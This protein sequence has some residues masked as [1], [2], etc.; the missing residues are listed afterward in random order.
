[1]G[2]L[3]SSYLARRGSNR[4]MCYNRWNNGVY[5]LTCH[6]PDGHE[7]LHRDTNGET[8]TSEVGW[9]DQHGDRE[10]T[11]EECVLPAPTHTD[12]MVSPEAIDE[13]LEANP[14]EL[15]EPVGCFNCRRG[16]HEQCI[17]DANFCACKKV[18]HE[19]AT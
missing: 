11:P 14:P 17:F 6:E 2:T 4:D 19:V 7:G 5:L 13:V 15:P 9:F 8:W 18:N 12:L 10:R 16:Q 3:S 1:M